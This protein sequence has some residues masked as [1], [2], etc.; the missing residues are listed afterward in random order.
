MTSIVVLLATG[1][2]TT[3]DVLGV[4]SSSA[5]ITVGAMFIL[6]AALERTGVIDGIGRLVSRAAERSPAQAIGVMMLG[7]MFLSAFIN[8]T[9]VVVILTPVVIGLAYAQK[10]APS[11]LLIPLSFASIFGGTM[12]LIGT[13]TNILVDGVAQREAWRRLVCSKS[14]CWAHCRVRWNYLPACGWALVVAGSGDTR[15]DVTING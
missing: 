7:V 11:K 1:I 6:S 3:H 12:T 15:L 14:P 13:S 2:L 5:P 10:V 4:F 9:P 8:N